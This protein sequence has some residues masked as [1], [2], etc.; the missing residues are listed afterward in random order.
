MS[1]AA[2]MRRQAVRRVRRD[3]KSILAAQRRGLQAARGLQ[4]G[5]AVTL[6]PVFLQDAAIRRSERICISPSL[7][8]PVTL[9]RCPT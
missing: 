2:S 8:V 3:F 7:S 6:E 5:Q 9:T 4:V 1:L